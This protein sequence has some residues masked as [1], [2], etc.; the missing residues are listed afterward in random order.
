MKAAKAQLCIQR[1]MLITA[2]LGFCVAGYTQTDAVSLFKQ[3]QTY[4]D[5]GQYN[6]ALTFVK[7]VVI[8][9]PEESDYHL[10]L[11]KCYGKLAENTNWIKALSLAK[12]THR[13]LERAVELD[14]ENIRALRDLMHYYRQAPGFLGGNKA[15]AKEIEQFLAGVEITSGPDIAL[16]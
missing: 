13:S 2:L 14:S 1:I 15:K 10:L 9:V 16:D 5:V 7:Q 8:L 3:A 4:Y 6:E 12:K 11:G